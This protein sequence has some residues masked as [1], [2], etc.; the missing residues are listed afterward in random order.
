M[1]F[2]SLYSG[3]RFSTKDQDNDLWSGSRAGKYKGAWWY[4]ICHRSN[5]NGRYLGGPHDAFADGIN[6]KAFRDFYYS[7]KGCDVKLRSQQRQKVSM[8]RCARTSREASVFFYLS[9]SE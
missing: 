8:E 9:A 4:K 1:A 7:L 3:M 6:W 5:L 2:L